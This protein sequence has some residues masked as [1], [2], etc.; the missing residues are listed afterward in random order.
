MYGY[1]GKILRVDLTAGDVSIETLDEAFYRRYLGGRALAAYFLL[2]EVPPRIDPFDPRNKLIFAVSVVTGAPVPGANRFLVAAKSPL[3][4][5]YG[6]A[7][8]GGFW[9]PELKFAGFDAIIVEGRAEKPVYLWIHDGEAEIRDAGRLWG[10]TTKETQEEIRKELGDS[11]IRVAAIGPAGENL[12]RYACIISEGKYANGRGGMGAVMGSKNLKAVAVRGFME[13]KFYDE[14]K[15][16]DLARKFNERMRENPGSVSRSTYGTAELVLPLNELGM[17]PTRNFREGVFEGAEKISGERMKETILVGRKGCYACPIG[18][19]RVV[20]AKEPYATDPDYGGPEYETI[21]SLGSL[22]GIDDLSAIAYANQ[23]CNAYG[24]D[25]I[26]TGVTIAFAMECYER[27]ILTKDD[28][29]GI[30]L[31]FGNKDA[32]LRLVEMIAKR[33]GIGDLLAEGV[34]RAAEKI[35]KGAEKIAMHVKG[36]EVPMHEPRGKVGVGLMYAVSPVGADHLQAAHD[37]GLEK[38]PD[39]YKPLGILEPMDRFSLGP[40]KVR[41]IVYLQMWWSLLNCLCMCLFTV[42]PH[43]SGVFTVDDVRE[44]VNAVT[45]W[46]MSLWELMKVGERGITMLRCFNIREGIGRKD[47]TLPERLFEPLPSGPLEGRRISKEEL[48]RAISLYYEMLGW[49]PENGVPR[50]AKLYEL[51]LGWLV[52]LL[53]ENEA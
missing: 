14:S 17:L 40:E 33:E 7:E 49:D 45:G 20:V 50:A 18:C 4:N 9:G 12:V 28:T 46:N 16:R 31:K 21:A 24:L 39:V 2:R 44:I 13:P 25:T 22:C 23:L 43:P 15:L 6:E 8:A 35:G 53:S 51:D 11:R 52:K 36:K 37:T 5:T 26:S 1:N 41:A 27:G 38:L 30:E 32:M 48:D 29:G 34:M 10:K 47:D 3:T 42:A 19:K